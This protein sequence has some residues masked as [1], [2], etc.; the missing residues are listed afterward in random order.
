MQYT[1]TREEYSYDDAAVPDGAET[2]PFY[3]FRNYA[4]LTINTQRMARLVLKGES[5][6]SQPQC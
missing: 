3:R 6:F 2:D 1:T 4:N 5:L